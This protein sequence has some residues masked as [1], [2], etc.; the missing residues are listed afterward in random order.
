MKE[1]EVP[2]PPEV[3]PLDLLRRLEERF[4]AVGVTSRGEL[5]VNL[6]WLYHEASS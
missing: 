4:G 2:P 5:F 6:S 1:F 3:E